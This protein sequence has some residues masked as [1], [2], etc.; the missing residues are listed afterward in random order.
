MPLNPQ[1]YICATK[2]DLLDEGKKRAVRFDLTTQYSESIGAT[3]FETSC[4]TGANVSAM[5]LRIAQDLMVT[6]AND[7]NND[8]IKLES[9]MNKEKSKKEECC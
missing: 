3:L 2:I 4:K 6:I 7:R 5:F 1:I 9:R 8:T